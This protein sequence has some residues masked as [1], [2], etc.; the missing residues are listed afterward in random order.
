ML[1]VDGWREV[2]EGLVWVFLVVRGHP[3]VDGFS[4]FTE[5]IEEVGIEH[6]AAH[7]SVEALDISVLGRFAWLDVM[8]T[9]S[10]L[11]APCHELG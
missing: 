6:F 5:A 3:L 8:E 1:F 9:N 10:V 7:A 4:N 11:L 2:S